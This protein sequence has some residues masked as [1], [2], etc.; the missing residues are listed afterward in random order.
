M[1]IVQ[2][3]PGAGGMYCGNCFRDNALVAELRAQGHAALMVPLYLPMTL[4][5]P[6]Q[7][8]GS[9]IFFG[10]IS[11]YLQQQSSLFARMPNWLR[12]LLASPNLLKLASGRAAKTRP[13]E[14]G[15]MTLSM[16]KG[17]QGR[18]NRE[19]E[20][21]VGWLGTQPSPDIV[22][23][24]NALLV[25]MAR[26]I[27]SSLGCP[28]AV[29][30]QGED[31]FLDSL[32][33]PYSTRCWQEL[34]LRAREVDLFIAPSRYYGDLMT[35]R[36][37]LRREQVQ[38]VHNGI[39]LQGYELPSPHAAGGPPILGYFTRMCREKGLDRLIRAFLIARRSVPDLRLKV[40]GACGPSDEPF[41][42]ECRQEL[43]RAG[44]LDSAEFHKNIDRSAKVSFLQSLSF[45]SVPAR[46]KEDYGLYLLES[47][48]AGTPVV[49]PRHCAFPEIVNATGGGVICDNNEESLAA[50]YVSLARDPARLGELSRAGRESVL[51]RFG[52]ASMARNIVDAYASVSRGTA[53]VT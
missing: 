52:A 38:V 41:V 21:L 33:E 27:R 24:S 10:G 7:S 18:Q 12:N 30:L 40:G 3:T 44:A 4:D 34:S 22:C 32:G 13:S 23:L 39:N 35:S 19:L 2:I 29:V 51:A 42:E 6:D 53:A 14:L 9:P 11:V 47:M 16:L 43:A 5:E 8:R 26:A 46:Y 17:E 45:L 50:A 37:G 49:Q 48:A 31:E 20:E 36:L 1:N 28:V 15:E 25:G